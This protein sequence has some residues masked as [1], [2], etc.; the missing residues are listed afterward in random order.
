VGTITGVLFAP[1]TGGRLGCGVEASAT[2]CALAEAVVFGV[3]CK[4]VVPEPTGDC[5][6]AAVP[7]AG[8][9]CCGD[10]GCGGRIGGARTGT[11][12]P[13]PV[14][15]RDGMKTAFPGRDSRAETVGL[16]DGGGAVC[17]GVC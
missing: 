6:E 3:D 14:A 1:A 7:D 8:G 17:T 15:V 16:R 5:P 9:W 4:P 10:A 13:P 11:Q 12:Y 2:G